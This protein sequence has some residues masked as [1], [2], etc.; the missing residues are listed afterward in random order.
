MSE[1]GGGD[2]EGADDG[3]QRTDGRVYSQCSGSMSIIKAMAF[4]IRWISWFEMLPI[5]PTNLFMAN[6]PNLETVNC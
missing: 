3:W 2:R 6:G 1:V 4:F 5:F